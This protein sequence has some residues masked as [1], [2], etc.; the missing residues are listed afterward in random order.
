M[1]V[2]KETQL[3]AWLEENMPEPVVPS[4]Y[5]VVTYK[6]V[7]DVTEYNGAVFDSFSFKENETVI[8]GLISSSWAVYSEPMTE[9]PKTLILTS[10]SSVTVGSFSGILEI[11]FSG[12]GYTVFKAYIG[13]AYNVT[14]NLQNSVSAPTA[15]GWTESEEK[16]WPYR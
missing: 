15:I 16:E 6:E 13:G 12:S 14:Q 8:F 2:E 9:L 5:K 10:A 11:Q 4:G 7:N 1:A 3:E